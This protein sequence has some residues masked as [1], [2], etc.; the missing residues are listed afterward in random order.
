MTADT[1]FPASSDAHDGAWCPERYWLPC[2]QIAKQH[3]GSARRPHAIYS[4]STLVSTN[5]KIFLFAGGEIASDSRERAW[6]P[7]LSP[8]LPSGWCRSSC[9]PS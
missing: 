4:F 5:S 8:I 6:L 3:D 2:Y 7:R 9:S 1:H